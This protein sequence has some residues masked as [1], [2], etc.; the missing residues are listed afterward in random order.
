MY[1]ETSKQPTNTFLRM[2]KKEK[3]HSKPMY[4]IHT[5]ASNTKIPLKNSV[6]PRAV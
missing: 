5:V 3:M 6:N 2:K 4:T 1:I